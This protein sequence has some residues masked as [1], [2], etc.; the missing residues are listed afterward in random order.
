MRAMADIQA[1]GLRA[2]G[3]LLERVL[4]SEP[5]GAGPRTRSPAGDYTALVDAWAGLLRRIA[6]GLAQPVEPGPV[7]VPL[8][9]NGIG[10]PVRLGCA[11]RREPATLPSKSG[12]TT[13]RSPTSAR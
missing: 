10:P 9:S 12:F 8:D 5:D 6:A 13:E 2:A 11:A 3:E 4:G 1:E 7:T